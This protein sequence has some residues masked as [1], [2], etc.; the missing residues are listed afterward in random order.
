MDVDEKFRIKIDEE[1]KQR[2]PRSPLPQVYEDIYK[3]L[4]CN[5]QLRLNGFT[6]TAGTILTG[7]SDLLRT[8]LRSEQIYLDKGMLGVWSRWQHDLPAHKLGHGFDCST[9]VL[10]DLDR[11]DTIPHLIVSHTLTI[12]PIAVTSPSPPKYEG[13]AKQRKTVRKMYVPTS[14]LEELINGCYFS[15]FNE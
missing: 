11:P 9:W 1:F 15:E 12:Y 14:S 5:S 4:S 7:F 2:C 6:R 13:W 8:F 10:M 3:S